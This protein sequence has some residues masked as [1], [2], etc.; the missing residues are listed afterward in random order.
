[1]NRVLAATL[2][3]AVAPVANAW[4]LV[5]NANLDPHPA[6]WPY[7][8]AVSGTSSALP[9]GTHNR[10][11]GNVSCGGT[12]QCN[13]GPLSSSMSGPGNTRFIYPMGCDQ[14]D[15]IACSRYT[16]TS[17]PVNTGMTW[18]A[19]ISA[20]HARFGSAITRYSAFFQGTFHPVNRFCTSWGT[21]APAYNYLLP[22]TESCRYGLP[23]PTQ[24]NVSG[25]TVDLN[26]NLLK[27]GEI[28]GKTVRITR[29]VNCSRTTPVRYT[30]S[31]GNP[32]DLG[33]G[34]TSALSVNGRRA[35][36]LIHLPSGTSNLIFS[37]TLTD[38]GA[39]L[40][41]FSKTIILIQSFM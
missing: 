33:N 21:Y 7:E 3:L 16:G 2:L 23:L 28:T 6:P 37:S 25:G 34:V 32:V 24:C 8:T 39:R 35:G 38:N 14:S 1:M 12:W 9:T 27:L 5:N 15:H 26:H 30:V 10:Y 22:G 29:S 19:A 41:P 4:N 13:F 11:P 40:G 18:E 31:V 17:V 36:D 20:W